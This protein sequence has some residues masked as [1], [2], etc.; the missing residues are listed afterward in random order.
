MHFWASSNTLYS[1]FSAAGGLTWS[2]SKSP[3]QLITDVTT[4]D[5]AVSN[6]ETRFSAVESDVS[7]KQAAFSAGEGLQFGINVA[8]SSPGLQMLSPYWIAVKIATAGTILTAAGRYTFTCKRFQLGRYRIEWTP[9]HPA[10]RRYIY[11]VSQELGVSAVV[12]SMTEDA[13]ET[14]TSMRVRFTSYQDADRDTE[15]CFTILA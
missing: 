7:S 2:Y 10:G 11:T 8:L 12:H 13:G 14:Y 15:F 1:P 4:L 6:H 3:Q 5:S 9:A